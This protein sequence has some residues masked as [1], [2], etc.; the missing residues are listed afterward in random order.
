MV[1]STKPTSN[2]GILSDEIT[3]SGFKDIVVSPDKIIMPSE[4]D[5][6]IDKHH[7]PETIK[8]KPAK[9]HDFD[10]WDGGF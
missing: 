7:L 2:G 3:Y 5:S 6:D 8:K 1:S 10:G 9:Q 4:L